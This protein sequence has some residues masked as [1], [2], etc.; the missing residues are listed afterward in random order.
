MTDT[1][2]IPKRVL[3]FALLL[4]LAAFIGYLIA[5]GEFE[6]FAGVVLFAGILTI[7]LMLRGHHLLLVLSWNLSMNLF[8]LPGSPPMWMLSSLVSFGLIVLAKIMDRDLKLL[9]VPSVTWAL[10]AL[11]LVV[12]FTM[13]ATGTLGVRSLGGASYGGKKY[14]FILFAIIG[15]FCLSSIRIPPEKLRL[16]IGAFLIPGLSPIIGNLIYKVPALWFLFAL[17]PSDNVMLLATEDFSIDPYS[18]RIGRVQGLAFASTALLSY[19]LARYGIRGILDLRQPWRL[20]LLIVALVVGLFGGFRSVLALNCGLIVVQFF[21]EG[22]HRTKVFP[23]FILVG[24]L[25]LSAIIPLARKLPL[26]VQRA[27]SVLPIDVSPAARLDAMGSTDWRLRMWQ[28]A[29]RDVPQHLWVG[30]G[31]TASASEYFLTQ[32]ASRYGM[33]EDYEL[34]LIAGDYHNGPLSILIPFGVFGMLAFL[35]FLWAGSSVLYQNFRYGPSNLKI[36]NAFLLSCFAVRVFFF[37]AVFGGVHSD[38][39]VLVGL[40]GFSVAINNGICKRRASP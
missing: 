7:P 26:S 2:A 6:S 24:I 32:Q 23:V 34:S 35:A 19:L 40:V 37:F 18:S 17:F 22:M 9:N 16:Y 38:I 36:I 10:L 30:K 27:L 28:A 25:T 33:A 12:V 11:G 14:F 13:A 8:F 4:P 20:M 5:D 3:I 39:V 1:F 29:M 31:Y 15:Y 21:L